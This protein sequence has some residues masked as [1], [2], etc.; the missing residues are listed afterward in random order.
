[1]SALGNRTD[2][3]ETETEIERRVSEEMLGTIVQRLRDALD[4]EEIVLFG[5]QAYGEPNLDSDVDILIIMHSDLPRRERKNLAFAALRGIRRQVDTHVYTPDEIRHAL[6]IGNFF[7]REMA[8]RGR[9]LYTRGP[10]CHPNGCEGPLDLTFEIGGEVD[11]VTDPQGWVAKAEEDH[12]TARIILRRKKPFTAIACFHVQQCVE[13]YF[14][15]VLVA[16]GQ[17]FP[18]IHDLVELAE[19]M[20]QH[21]MIV[22]FSADSLKKLTKCAVEARY[23]GHEPTI[24]DVREALAMAQTVRRFARRLIGTA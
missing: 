10:L 12:E 19:F 24:E 1:M 15:A 17:G 6:E 3:A 23:P 21:G 2:V 14:K 5:S 13:K 11:E 22:P 20:E 16:R 9:V 7:V 8:I 4:P 18:K